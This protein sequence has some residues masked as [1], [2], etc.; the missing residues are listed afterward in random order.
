MRTWKRMLALALSALTLSGLLPL[1]AS[2]A[3]S[4][5]VDGDQITHTEA[6]D[7]MTALGVFQGS[8]DAFSPNA[9]L[10]REQAAKILCAMLGGLEEAEQLYAGT[11]R[12]SDVP[13]SRWSAPYIAYCVENNI[14]AGDGSGRF[15]PEQ[16]LTG[17]SFAKMLLVALGYD[18]TTEGY[19]GGDWMLN[20]ASAASELGLASQDL[21]LTR[22]ISRQ[23]AALMCFQTLTCD[24]VR[25]QGRSDSFTNRPAVGKVDGYYDHDYN[26]SKD[27]IQQFC[28]AYFPDLELTT[29]YDGF[30]RPGSG[31]Q[32]K[33]EKVH[34]TPHTPAA[35][36]SLSTSAQ[37]VADTLSAC[38]FKDTYLYGSS[39]RI[40]NSKKITFN[41]A[42]NLTYSGS[43]ES[44]T[45]TACW[46]NDQTTADFLAQFTENGRQV[47]IYTGEKNAIT[48][49]VVITYQVDTLSDVT[50]TSGMTTYT[51]G[52][53]GYVD[54]LYSSADTA[55]LHGEVKTGDTVTYAV[56]DG[57]A[58]I[59]PTRQ[60]TGTLTSLS[61]DQAVISGETY[62]LATGVSGVAA[63]QPDTDGVFCLD[64]SGSVVA[65]RSE[66]PSSGY[67]MVLGTAGAL[68]DGQPS[69]TAQLLLSDGT[70]GQFSVALQTLTAADL[71]AGAPYGKNG[72]FGPN[73]ANNPAGVIREGAGYVSASAVSLEVGDV[74][75]RNTNLLVYDASADSQDSNGENTSQSVAA[76]AD[77]SGILAYTRQGNTVA[78]YPLPDASDSMT[79]YALYQE[80]GLDVSAMGGSSQT[81]RQ[82]SLT[83]NSNT[84]FVI[85]DPA[86]KQAVCYEGI[87]NLPAHVP[88]MDSADVVIRAYAA[89]AGEA[90]VIFGTS[91]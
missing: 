28:E 61:D 63:L 85:Y 36:F 67:A 76:A 46:I 7:V 53:A 6:V 16:P 8:G 3:S 48:D 5:F 49:I 2:A 42:A 68:T 50:V 87:V 57:V 31:W 72:S 9:T 81:G 27:G 35:V 32:W 52:G 4:D 77:L 44:S 59:Y 26:G 43:G 30:G 79:A 38:S 90:A 69:V 22:S 73:A 34:Y 15:Y 11:Q 64:Q 56:A 88:G 17:A 21:D 12:F 1:P 29:A 41:A 58:H 60:V 80:S 74:V 37:E 75:I 39:E 71:T 62:P 84:L 18:P 47:E 13:A 65:M 89:D 20:V 54:Y 86:V 83:L 33:G 82:Y 19:T 55:V 14:L 51:I 70:V 40:T 10:T 78:L 23:D 45:Q 25:Y 91:N 66:E 24:M